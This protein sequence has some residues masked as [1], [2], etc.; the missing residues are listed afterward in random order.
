MADPALTASSPAPTVDGPRADIGVIGGSGLYDFLETYD[1]VE[2]DTPFGPPSDPLVVGEVDGR[3]VAFVARHGKGH[4]FAPHRVN[5]RANLWALRAVGVRQVLSP[6]AVGSLRPENGPGT[7]VVPDQ[8]VDRTWGRGHTVYEQEGPVV[9]IGFAD[10]FCPRGRSVALGSVR[11]AGLDAVDG[12]TLVVVNGPRFSSRAESVMHQQQGWSVVGMTTMPEAA[13]AREL[14]LCFTTIAMVTDHDA[15]VEGGEAVS[16][17]EVL[18]VFAANVDR[19]KGVLRD[20]IGDLPEPESDA[21][22]TCPCRRALDGIELPFAL[23]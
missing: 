13:I 23:P 3:R 11:R 1:T 8:V 15:G 20:A 21:D 18:R 19:L 17:D 6:C 9:H 12:G 7:V 22:A 4:R 5:Y 16:H 14:A 10:P 2:V